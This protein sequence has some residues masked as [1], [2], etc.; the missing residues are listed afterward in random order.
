[1]RGTPP[2]RPLPV[3]S[4]GQRPTLAE[5]RKERH[6][7][8]PAT[9]FAAIDFETADEGSDSACAVAIVTMQDGAIVDRIHHLIRPPRR[10]IRFSYIRAFSVSLS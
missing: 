4:P 10:H 6:T 3:D 2:P 1:M 5:I 8:P 7:E 9:R